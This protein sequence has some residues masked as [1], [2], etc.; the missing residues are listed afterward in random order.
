MLESKCRIPLQ[1][2]ALVK[3]G[4]VARNRSKT[5]IRKVT[6]L[7]NVACK[8]IPFK[9]EFWFCN[10]VEAKRHPTASKNW[11]AI[12]NTFE[13][14]TNK[15]TLQFE[16]ILNRGLKQ[17]YNVCSI[18]IGYENKSLQFVS[19]L[20]PVQKNKNMCVTVESV[21]KKHYNLYHVWIGDKNNITICATFASG[22]KK[23]YYLCHFWIG[24]KNNITSCATFDSGTKKTIQFVSR[25]NREQTRLADGSRKI[26]L[27]LEWELIWPS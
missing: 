26:T 19:R 21:T 1:V 27:Q 5:V 20:I 24:D 23:Q 16:S 10:D 3:N 17:H 8:M 2:I 25:L 15:K 22:T 4:Q 6:V 11:I 7:E 9:Q 18:W 14:G 13:S 12:C